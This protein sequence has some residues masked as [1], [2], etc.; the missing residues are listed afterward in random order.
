MTFVATLLGATTHARN[1]VW[2]DDLRLW[3]DATE[4]APRNAR[5]WMNAGHAA[6][7]RGDTA[8]AR[9]LLLEAHRLS[10]CY[11]YVQLNLSAAGGARGERGGVAH[12]GP[13]TPCAAIP[14]WRWRA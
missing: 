9:K 3:L 1:E 12:A 2:R 4:K 14:G 7:T 8:Q 11:A 5:A 10:P 6:L 13:T